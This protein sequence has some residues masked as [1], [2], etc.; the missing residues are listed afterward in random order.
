MDPLLRRV[1]ST[2]TGT[3]RAAC[4]LMT[5]FERRKVDFQ[6][7]LDRRRTY[8]DVVERVLR[9]AL[10]VDNPRRHGLF[11]RL[12]IGVSPWSSTVSEVEVH[13]LH[14]LDVA[15]TNSNS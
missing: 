10:P 6:R 1:T 14:D 8:I 7:T 4:T 12:D 2:M 9:S 3:G 15:P 5:F 13:L 11:K